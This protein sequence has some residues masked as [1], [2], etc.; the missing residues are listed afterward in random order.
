MAA[1]HTPVIRHPN[2]I[3][4]ISI[5]SVRSAP[6]ILA[7]LFDGTDAATAKQAGR[8]AGEHLAA[9]AGDFALAGSFTRPSQKRSSCGV[10]LK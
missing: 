8:A 10:Q 3:I 6:F 1:T 7:A 9:A 5:G 2:W 4:D